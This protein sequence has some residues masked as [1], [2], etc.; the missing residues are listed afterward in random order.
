MH[1]QLRTR[2]KLFCAC[3]TDFGAP[4]NTQTCPVCL[5][6]PGALPVLNAGAVE[7]ALRAAAALEC[8]VQPRSV[9]A[10]KNYFYPDLPKGYQISQYD[11][12]LAEGGAVRFE[13]GEEERTVGLI[14][15]HLEEDAGKS[16][17]DG[18]PDSHLASYV[19]LNRAGVPLIEI[20]SQ[21]ELH[22][23]E[24]AYL[25]LERLRSVLR[26]TQVCDGNLEE[27]SLRCDA[28]VSV[29]EA[30]T[31]VLGT[32]T[33]VKNLNSFRNVQRA[34]EHEIERQVSVVAAGGRVLQETRLWDPGEG[35]TRPMRGKEE[36][37]DYRYFPEPDL[38]PVSIPAQALQHVRAALPELPAA[39]KARFLARYGP[40]GVSVKEAH[41]LTLETTLAGWFEAVAELSGNPKAAANWTLNDLLRE[42]NAAGRREDDVPL[43]PTHAADLLR[44]VDAGVLS[45]TAAREV[46]AEIYRAGRSPADVAAERG[47]LQINEDD[48]L[49]RLAHEVLEA[50]PAQLAQYRAG[51]TAL[52][53]FFVGQAMKASKGRANPRTLDALLRELLG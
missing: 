41:L 12:P 29:R 53:G 10:R 48:A 5:G 9:F 8:R 18:F 45:V 37:Q 7:L 4:P 25:Y 39:R 44:M 21:P 6:H 11:E 13:L 14:R 26:Y 1:A 27:G 49:R 34:L 19:D 50:H 33:E 51:K 24:E 46:F 35:K 32:R 22:T 42:Q 15:L 40:A 36:A 43:D 31:Q 30:G 47:L 52:F 17:H 16:L 2:S 38:P 28:N 3:A 20:V 23:P